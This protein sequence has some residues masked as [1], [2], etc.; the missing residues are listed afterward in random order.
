[1]LG[2]GTS[3]V[4]SGTVLDSAL[5]DDFGGAAVGYSVRRLNGDYYGPCM[6]V[7]RDSDNAERDIYFGGDDILDT[8]TLEDF[9]SGTDGYVVRW[10]NQTESY[11]SLKLLNQ[12]YASSPEAAYSVRKL[13]SSY[14]GACMK[15]AS[16]TQAIGWKYPGPQQGGNVQLIA[17]ALT[18]ETYSPGRDIS[19]SVEVFVD[20]PS[21]VLASDPAQV[22]V[23]MGSSGYN[24]P[25]L[26]QREWTK[27]DVVLSA[28]SNNAINIQP[29]GFVGP[30]DGRYILV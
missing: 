30:H 27:V 24:S 23:T 13:D 2:L 14:D 20:T 7:R 28:V 12:S 25:Q 11:E 15:V 26:N 19:F 5:L 22:R 17:S 18:P 6:R 16:S 1:M 9:C 10:Y 3:I 8:A 21:R 4:T 29:F